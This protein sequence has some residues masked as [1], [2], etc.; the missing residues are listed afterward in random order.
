M[1]ALAAGQQVTDVFTYTVRAADATSSATLAI[2]VSG[3]N[4]GPVA[5]AD[6]GAI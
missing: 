4:D 3:T 2:T 5:K 1:Q 6:I